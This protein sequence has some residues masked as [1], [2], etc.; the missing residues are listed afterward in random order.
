MEL[1]QNLLL[2]ASAIFFVAFGCLMGDNYR[3]ALALATASAVIMSYYFWLDRKKEVRKSLLS[4]DQSVWIANHLNDVLGEALMQY[5]EARKN[6]IASSNIGLT[7]HEQ[8]V[9]FD[10]YGKELL[11]Q[12]REE[13]PSA[14]DIYTEN[15]EI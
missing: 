8:K 12:L 11:E 14:H 10:L 15:I 7:S 4:W 9:Q 6:Y 5:E 13:L 3:M 1:K 2:T